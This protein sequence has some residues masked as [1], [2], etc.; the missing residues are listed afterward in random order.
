MRKESGV[1]LRDSVDIAFTYI[2]EY[3]KVSFTAT[4]DEHIYFDTRTFWSDG[5]TYYRVVRAS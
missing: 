4:A 3:K 2:D 5:T 1:L